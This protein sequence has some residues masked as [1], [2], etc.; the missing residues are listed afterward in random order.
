VTGTCPIEMAGSI[1][2]TLRQTGRRSVDARRRPAN[3]PRTTPLTDG[4]VRGGARR[5]ATAYHDPRSRR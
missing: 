2:R 4:S 3:Q 1:V 5:P